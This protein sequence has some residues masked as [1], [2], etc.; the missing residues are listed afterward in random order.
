MCRHSE[1]ETLGRQKL[2]FL[3]S[4]REPGAAVFSRFLADLND[5]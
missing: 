5:K 2:S 4:V 3:E 1:I